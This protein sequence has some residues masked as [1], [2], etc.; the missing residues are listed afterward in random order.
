MSEIGCFPGHP[1]RYTLLDVIRDRQSRT[2]C[3]RLAA[4]PDILSDIRWEGL[5]RV[6]QV[7]SLVSHR[8]VTMPPSWLLL[9]GCR[10]ARSFTFWPN[11]GP[12][13]NEVL[14]SVIKAILGSSFWTPGWV[15]GWEGGIQLVACFSLRVCAATAQL[16]KQFRWRT[17]TQNGYANSM[18]WTMCLNCLG[19]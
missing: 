9:R 10:L 13:K 6:P 19:T 14:Q 8:D 1:V 12:K 18:Q 11:F 15:G 5:L 4:L 16:C 7:L 2:S 3:P 17:R